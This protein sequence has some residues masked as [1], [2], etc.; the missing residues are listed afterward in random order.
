MIALGIAL[1]ALTV[2]ATFFIAFAYGMSDNIEDNSNMTPTYV[3]LIGTGLSVLLIVC[4][5]I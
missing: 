4:G 2:I 1:F 3:F 5:L